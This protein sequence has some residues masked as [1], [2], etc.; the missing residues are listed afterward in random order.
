MD[1]TRAYI[2]ACRKRQLKCGRGGDESTMWT[3]HDVHAVFDV[4]ENKRGKGETAYDNLKLAQY[5]T[6]LSMAVNGSPR[7][8]DTTT[9]LNKHLQFSDKGGIQYIRT[10]YPKEKSRIGASKEVFSDT[11]KDSCQYNT[12]KW[13][14]HYLQELKNAD[15]TLSECTFYA[16]GT[17]AHTT[18]S[19]HTFPVIYK[20]KHGD[21]IIKPNL[22]YTR[23]NAKTSH[24]RWPTVSTSSINVWLLQLCTDWD[25]SQELRVHGLRGS[26]AYLA[27]MQFGNPEAVRVRMGWQPGSKMAEK[28]ARIKQFQSLHAA[29]TPL[30]EYKETVGFEWR[31]LDAF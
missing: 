21:P 24:L 2:S 27:F 30:P 18:R 11:S 22:K 16:E 28:Y 7:C 9:L 19:A 25:L 31:H 14:G 3:H 13:F 8:T 17:D 4:L 10:I 23:G 20:D 1:Q 29:I 26:K 12:V 6:I 5:A 15:I